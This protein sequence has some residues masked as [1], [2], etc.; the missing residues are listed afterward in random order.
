M[1]PER[2]SGVAALDL[3]YRNGIAVVQGGSRSALK[4]GALVA[5]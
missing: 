3:R 4:D 1:G 2:L 5:R